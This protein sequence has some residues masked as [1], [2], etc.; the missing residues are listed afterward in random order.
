MLG[1][2][3]VLV[4]VE[5]DYDARAL[6]VIT[7][8]LTRHG[9][10]IAPLVQGAFSKSLFDYRNKMWPS[11]ARRH[12]NTGGRKGSIGSKHFF[13]VDVPKS[14]QSVRRVADAGG[15]IVAASKAGVLLEEGGAVR[16][17]MGRFMAIP[18]KSP[19]VRTATGKIKSQFKRGP[20]RHSFSFR[21]KAR[22]GGIPS[23]W[24]TFVK[25]SKRGTLTIYRKVDFEKSKR[26]R[27]GRPP[28]A[29]TGSGKKKTG[30]LEALF[31][32]VPGTFHTPKL[33]FDEGVRAYRPIVEKNVKKKI[34][35][36]IRKAF[37]PRVVRRNRS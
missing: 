33:R 26:G 17:R 6:D 32:L 14:D 1:A 21:G 37:A 5:L 28:G 16:P 22:T 25:R 7:E 31:F 30:K 18:S 24:K 2:G 8:N 10:I 13:K 11:H 12:I 23:N 20:G 29:T 27:R 3:G 15:A 9:E 34:E 36:G 4:T 19:L 35:D